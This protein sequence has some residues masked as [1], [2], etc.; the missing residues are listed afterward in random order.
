MMGRPLEVFGGNWPHGSWGGY[1]ADHHMGSG[2]WGRSW[3]GLKTWAFQQW[4]FVL[5]GGWEPRGGNQGVDTKRDRQYAFKVFDAVI[6][7]QLLFVFW[8]S[9]CEAL[10]VALLLKGS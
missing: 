8:I 1:L 6:D 5:T 4:A 3:N 7:H 2:K 10:W 9:C